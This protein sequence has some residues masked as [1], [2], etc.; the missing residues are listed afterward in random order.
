L[1]KNLFL[2]QARGYVRGSGRR[3]EHIRDQLSPAV[4]NAYRKQRK[5]SPTNVN[6]ERFSLA[7]RQLQ[8]VCTEALRALA[9]EVGED[10]R[11][12]VRHREFGNLLAGNGTDGGRRR[13]PGKPRISDDLFKALFRRKDRRKGSKSGRQLRGQVEWARWWRWSGMLGIAS[14]SYDEAE[15]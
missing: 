2:I 5:G 3:L 9:R 11:A 15:K 4:Q 8:I 10:E 13:G 14:R 1:K 7:L 12:Y 6:D